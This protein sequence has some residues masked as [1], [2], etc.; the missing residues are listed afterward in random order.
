MGSFLPYDRIGELFLR[1]RS[2]LSRVLQK[3][4]AC[5]YLLRTVPHSANARRRSTRLGSG[6]AIHFMG[7]PG[8]LSSTSGHDVERK[9]HGSLN[10]IIRALLHSASVCGVAKAAA[11]VV[12]IAMPSTVVSACEEQ[13]VA[14]LEFITSRFTTLISACICQQVDSLAL[15]IGSNKQVPPSLRGGRSRGEWSPAGKS[16]LHVRHASPLNWDFRLGSSRHCSHLNWD[17]CGV[18]HHVSRAHRRR[19]DGD[20]RRDRHRARNGGCHLDVVPYHDRVGGAE[21]ELTVGLGDH[22]ADNTMP[23]RVRQAVNDI[24]DGPERLVED[25]Q[26]VKDAADRLAVQTLVRSHG[27]A[28]GPSYKAAAPTTSEVTRGPQAMLGA[29]LGSSSRT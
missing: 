26:D 12:R 29:S 21:L 10:L 27:R 24:R 14:W 20:R 19:R 7:S 8:F 2:K 17:P 25:R 13:Q 11:T 18:E 1:V 23:R 5:A 9:G 4:V 22:A 15:Y 3:H 6:H 28:H 16:A